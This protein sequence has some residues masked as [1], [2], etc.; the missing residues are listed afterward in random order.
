MIQSLQALQNLIYNLKGHGL[1]ERNKTDKRTK[2]INP[3]EQTKA[4]K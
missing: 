3:I 2:K 1:K 4:L